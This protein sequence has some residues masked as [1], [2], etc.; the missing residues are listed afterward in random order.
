MVVLPPVFQPSLLLIRGGL[1][2]AA[3]RTVGY[4]AQEPLFALWHGFDLLSSVSC[5][6]P[7]DSFPPL[8]I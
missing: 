4:R 7:T 3:L 1:G 6:Q 8:V 2:T 5:Y